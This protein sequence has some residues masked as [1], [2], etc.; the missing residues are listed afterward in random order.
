MRSSALLPRE[1]SRTIG[2]SGGDMARICQSE[3]SHVGR[4]CVLKTGSDFVTENDP[5][6]SVFIRVL[7]PA[8]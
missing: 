7:I 8:V 6:S 5:C 4:P 1:L 3:P 2:K